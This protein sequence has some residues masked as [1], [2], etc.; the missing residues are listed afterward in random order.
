[1]KKVPVWEV[2]VGSRARSSSAAEMHTGSVLLVAPATKESF[3]LLWGNAAG[4][5]SAHLPR[6]T[7]PAF[8]SGRCFPSEWSP[9]SCVGCGLHPLSLNE[10]FQP[11]EKKTG[12]WG[13]TNK[14]RDKPQPEATLFASLTDITG[15]SGVPV[16]YKRWEK[17]ER[18][19]PA[20]IAS[21]PLCPVTAHI[22]K[23]SCNTF[24]NI[25]RLEN[26]DSNPDDL[27]KTKQRKH[28]DRKFI[29]KSGK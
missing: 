3:S 15:E 1:M 16:A 26:T 7:L 9:V 6:E 4:S 24:N 27:N 5:S 10:K 14:Q 12:Y 18:A 28:E 23:A 8:D 13:G 2:S 21:D 19:Y 11:K 22:S 20:S 25:P 17:R 29:L